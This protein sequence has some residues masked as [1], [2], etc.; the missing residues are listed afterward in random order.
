MASLDRNAGNANS[1]S[2]SADTALGMKL[3]DPSDEMAQKFGL[4]D[5]H[6]GALVTSVEPNSAAAHA[7]LRPGDLITKVGSEAVDSAKAA[8][9][10]LSKQ[11]VDK[12][13][14]L[15]VSSREGARFVFVQKE[16]DK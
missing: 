6:D 9:D 2:E 15:Y 8:T 3:S 14:R 11:N 7:G 10:A 4:G 1:E 12:G 16:N 13:I 5:S